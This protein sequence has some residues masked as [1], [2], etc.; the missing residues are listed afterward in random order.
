[1]WNWIKKGKSPIHSLQVIS[2]LY[3]VHADPLMPLVVDEDQTTAWNGTAF[4]DLRYPFPLND[5]QTE[6]LFFM[7]TLSKRQTSPGG[8]CTVTKDENCMWI[9]SSTYTECDCCTHWLLWQVYHLP[10]RT[11]CCLQTAGFLSKLTK[12]GV[13]CRHLRWI[14]IQLMPLLSTLTSGKLT[15]WPTNLTAPPTQHYKQ[16]RRSGYSSV[17]ATRPILYTELLLFHP[18]DCVQNF[19]GEHASRPPNLHTSYTYI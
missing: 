11:F 14:P 16:G 18:Q 9:C 3:A 6:N 8:I 19:P 1:M 2:Y 17:V 15:Y 5:N 13:G 12:M 7:H 10:C 4:P